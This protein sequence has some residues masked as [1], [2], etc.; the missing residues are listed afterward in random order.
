MALVRI[1]LE[2]YVG[3]AGLGMPDQTFLGGFR[4]GRGRCSADLGVVVYETGSGRPVPPAD[5]RVGLLNAS[6]QDLTAA[7]SSKNFANATM[8]PP[9]WPQ[10]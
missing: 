1:I 6:V 8:P 5:D 3:G 7:A 10:S 4:L 2:A 9:A